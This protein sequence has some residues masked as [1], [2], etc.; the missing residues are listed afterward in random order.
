MNRMDEIS[1]EELLASIAAGSPNWAAVYER[2]R[3]AMF[4][5]ARRF[6]RT[7]DE[8]RRGTS[9]A[10][11]VQTVMAEMIKKGLPT[12]INSIER[13]RTFMVNV[14][15]RRTHNASQRL[16]AANE[17]FPEPGSPEELCDEAFEDYVHDQI[18]ASQAKV[19][20]ER[21]PDR[22]RHVIREH[23]LKG[24]TQNEVAADMRVS[25]GRIRQL[26]TAGLHRLR[27]LLGEADY[28]TKEGGT[29]HD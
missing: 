17:P 15:W 7:S 28:S 8:A 25:D 4:G 9:D 22:E 11:V 26:C 2:C 16:S 18:I 10:D 6:F 19:L 12:D 23:I 21:L 14:T 3:H 24:R 20:V 13:L 29:S 1:D 5:T 27:G